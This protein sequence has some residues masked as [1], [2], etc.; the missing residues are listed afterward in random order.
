MSASANIAAATSTPRRSWWRRLLRW[1]ERVL[2]G[3]G[4]LTLIY[5]CFFDVTA[6]VSESM[7]P[8]LVGTPTTQRDYVLSERITYWF[9]APRRWE[10][11]GFT[12]PDGIHVMKRVAA[13]PGETIA[14]RAGK[15]LINGEPIDRPAAIASR[16]YYPFGKLRGGKPYT[17]ES[18]YFVLGDDSRD[19]Y[20][21]RYTG[22]LAR[23]DVDGR[24]VLIVWPPNRMGWITP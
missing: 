14:V 3:F 2:A 4:G 21:S 19:S 11:V 17:C 6:I 18:G 5:L 1:A 20:D 22:E 13:F 16:I 8:T 10:I 12:N 24:A 15:P 23:D 9:R 7:K